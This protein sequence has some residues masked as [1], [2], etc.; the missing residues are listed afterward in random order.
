MEPRK[1]R[2]PILNLG[3]IMPN[4]PHEFYVP[5]PHQTLDCNN[6][7]ITV[8]DDFIIG[9]GGKNAQS[10]PPFDGQ[11]VAEGEDETK[12]EAETE[13]QRSEN[14]NEIKEKLKS[15]RKSEKS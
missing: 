14:I 15:M 4:Q 8:T 7:G 5:A 3:K 1:V 13:E 2:V 9:F 12:I 11:V 10:P 6:T